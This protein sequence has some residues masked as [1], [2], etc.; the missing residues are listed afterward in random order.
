MGYKAVGHLRKS[1]V[2]CVQLW[3][4]VMLQILYFRVFDGEV[5]GIKPVFLPSVPDVI[6]AICHISPFRLPHGP[7]SSSLWLRPTHSLRL[8]ISPLGQTTSFPEEP[9]TPW[10]CAHM[11]MGDLRCSGSWC[12]SYTVLSCPLFKITCV[13]K[14]ILLYSAEKILAS[15]STVS[16]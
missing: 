12:S 11:Q 1:L 8:C 6:L 16:F 9:Q 15:C 13:I 4:K 14:C 5:S 7:V 10:A 3:Y 2:L